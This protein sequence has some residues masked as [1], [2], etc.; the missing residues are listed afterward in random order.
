MTSTTETTVTCPPSSVHDMIVTWTDSAG[1]L[2]VFPADLIVHEGKFA[3][4]EGITLA[5]GVLGRSL[6]RVR[7]TGR[8]C[9][10]VVR[11]HEL[12]A[13]RRYDTGEAGNV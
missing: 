7:L 4:V 10:V 5:V 3:T 11:T 8:S 1:K 6:A 13:V 2:L 9:L 12:V